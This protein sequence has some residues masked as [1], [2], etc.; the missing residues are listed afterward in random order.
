VFFILSKILGFISHPL[1]WVVLLFIIF[2]YKNKTSKKK[3][4]F[5]AGLSIL[6][7]FS[8][9]IIVNEVL[10]WWEPKPV[11]VN[12]LPKYKMGVV[13]SGITMPDKSPHD[14]VYIPYGADRILHTVMLY[15]LGK[16]KKVFITG[17]SGRISKVLKAESHDMEAVFLMC[18]VPQEDIILEDK[19][20][21][22]RENALFTKQVLLKDTTEKLLLIT[23][24]YHMRRSEACFKKV[25]LKVDIFP[26]DYLSHD[27]DY[28]QISKILPS[29]SAIGI[30]V[31]LL[32][33]FIGYLTYSIAGYL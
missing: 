28:L 27:R 10:L 29:E 30:W 26:T 15:K 9:D 2:I 11:L 8:N 16:I 17:G 21:N 25:G 1:F 24:A 33:E 31:V 5:I 20:K 19:S 14:R 3:P 22:T 7:F 4:Y 18:G 12:D 13:L 23:S 6:L 32:H